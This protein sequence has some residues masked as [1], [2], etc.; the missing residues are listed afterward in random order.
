MYLLVRLIV[1]IEKRSE[2]ADERDIDTVFNDDFIVT[3]IYLNI[4][5]VYGIYIY[6]HLIQEHSIVQ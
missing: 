4:L 6:T 1:P 3:N 5:H 2:K